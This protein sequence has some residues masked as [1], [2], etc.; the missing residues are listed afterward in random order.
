[1]SSRLKKYFLYL[2]I[3]L[4]I[5]ITLFLLSRTTTEPLKPIESTKISG[6]YM[7]SLL[8][9]GPK[10]A[11][12]TLNKFKNSDFD[13]ATK[14]ERTTFATYKI[15][16]LLE[17]N[18]LDSIPYYTNEA[19]NNAAEIE[20]NRIQARL[21]YTLGSYYRL[22]GDYSKS[23]EYSLKGLS[24][25][26]VNSREKVDLYNNI[27]GIY[28]EL[29]D[30]DL[31]LDYLQKSYQGATSLKDVKRTAIAYA[32]IGNVYLITENYIPAKN[33]LRHSCIYFERINDTI[34]VIKSLTSISKIEL[35]QNNFAA[36]FS[37]LEQAKELSL[38][39]E[40]HSQ[41]S[42]VYQHYGNAYGGKKEYQ[43]AIDHYNEAYRL[44][45]K[46]QIARDKMNALD[47][48]ARNYDK[49][50]KFRE[51]NQSLNE[52]YR[53]KDSIYGVKVRQNIEELKWSTVIADQKLKNELLHRE[54]D[55]ERLNK[56]NLTKTYIII[57]VVI[58]LIVVFLWMLYKNNKKSLQ[59][60]NLSNDLLTDKI[61][62]D[63]NLKLIQE[64]QFQQ[65]LEIRNKELISLNILI[66]A[67]NKIFNDIE[68]IIEYGG[69]NFEQ[70]LY[71]LK[72]I[73]KSNRNQEND[74]EKFKKVFETVHPDFFKTIKDKFP[75]L[76]K[77]EIRVCTY[78]K[79]NM[80]STEICEMLN[81][82]QNSLNKGRYRIRKKLDLLGTVDLDE[83][84]KSW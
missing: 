11:E 19:L 34:N 47:G 23:L 65:E 9:E 12:L 51:A 69:M 68:S 46:N 45:R 2:A 78:I 33:N 22:I 79:M 83:F 25:S 81:I 48:L 55:T 58:L 80:P 17:K 43:T 5:A 77:T 3:F 44:S 57:I 54:V 49:L 74:W 59:I 8:L 28:F 53:I 14:K 60:A 82:N 10:K 18:K 73:I 38:N 1:M 35:M 21:Y 20:D 63:T 37:S 50:G 42:L 13:N 41:L 36:A 40:L 27:G 56:A 39:T 30:Y 84:V 61:T 72:N 76:S 67:K 70:T 4:L 62:A 52:Y 6:I 16:L 64:V 66:L 26:P 31:A 24:F 29:D 75:Q 32:N 7:D 71:E 15:I